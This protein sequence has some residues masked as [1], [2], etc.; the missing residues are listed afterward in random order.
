M[1]KKAAFISIG[2]AASLI[3]GGAVYATTANSDK[4]GTVIKVVDGDTLDIRIAGE[5]T[6]VRLLNVDTPETVD[7]NKPVECLGPEASGYLKALLEPGDKVDLE[8]DVEREDRYGR[9]LAGVFKD[10]DLVNRS[11]AEAG[12][13]IAVV[14]EPNRKFYQEVLDGEAQA[15]KR[16]EGLFS[17]AIDCTIPAHIDEATTALAQAPA[18]LGSTIEEAESLAGEAAAALAVGMAAKKALDALVPDTHP[19]GAALAAGK[20]SGKIATLKSSI[21]DAEALQ[22]THE[23]QHDKLVK[24]EKERKEAERKE[25][26]RKKKAEEARKA[27][28]RRQAAQKA[29]E[30][31]AAAERQAAAQRQAQN[32]RPR[33]QAP[34]KTAPRTTTPRTSVPKKYTGP[35]CYAPGGKSWRP[36]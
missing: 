7:P 17:P 20:F 11:I 13:G 19:V 24:E 22:E 6:R 31:R 26:E 33:I 8:Y 23:K 4:H 29:A 25:A 27:E 16:S 30:Q 21:R 14:Y 15:E 10:G 12:Y 1:A 9:T 5:D 2:V 32:S 35:R 34:R 28:E 36:C 3:A 18:E